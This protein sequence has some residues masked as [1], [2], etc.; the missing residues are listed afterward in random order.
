MS[1]SQSF[2]LINDAFEISLNHKRAKGERG[3]EKIFRRR[4]G[5]EGGFCDTHEKSKE[6]RSKISL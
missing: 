2:F 6:M 1:I 4:C 3:G 5:E